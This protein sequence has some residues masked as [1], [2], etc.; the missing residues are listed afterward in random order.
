MV[1][2]RN[3]VMN[4]VR[5]LTISA[6]QLLTVFR[7]VSLTRWGGPD[8]TFHI[9]NETWKS[10]LLVRESE[11]YVKCPSAERLFDLIIDTSVKVSMPYMIE[12]RF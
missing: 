7:I 10:P 9:L 4:Q 3:F 1:G 2:A 6:S 8:S 11:R 12:K 5:H